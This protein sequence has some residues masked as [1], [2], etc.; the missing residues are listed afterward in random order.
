MA[1][2]PFDPLAAI[3]ALGVIAVL[4]GFV[5][6]IVAQFRA[7]TAAFVR[8]ADTRAEIQRYDIETGRGGRAGE[9]RLRRAAQ[10]LVLI[11]FCATIGAAA[12][13]KFGFF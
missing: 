7:T 13:H 6:H 1:A 10:S 12:L 11:A 9:S 4:G 8:F 2:L 3:I 5:W